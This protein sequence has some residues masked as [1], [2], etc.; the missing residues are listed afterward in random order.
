M[1]QHPLKT[2]EQPLRFALFFGVHRFAEPGECYGF[3]P[4]RLLDCGQQRINR[5]ANVRCVPD[6]LAF[7]QQ[8]GLWALV[9]DTRTPRDL[10]GDIMHTFIVA[11]LLA[12]EFNGKYAQSVGESTSS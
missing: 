6:G 10:I 12:C 8:D 4:I 2:M 3:L 5:D 9:P 11:T 1:A 7:A